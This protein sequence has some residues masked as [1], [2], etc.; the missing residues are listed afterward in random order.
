MAAVLAA[1]GCS[2]STPQMRTDPAYKGTLE[3]CRDVA[4]PDPNYRARVIQILTKRGAT[5]DRCQRL[6]AGDRA[7]ATGIAIAAV[8]V[9]AGAA[10]ANN[11]GYYGGGGYGT[12]WDQFYN[13]Y[14]QPVWRCRDRSNGQFAFDY[15]CAGKPMIDST[16]PGPRL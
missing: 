3:L 15:Q 10:A 6:I 16:W 14:G 9:A 2:T 7:L 5:P 8:G 1:G 13:E 4:N 12:A 11:G